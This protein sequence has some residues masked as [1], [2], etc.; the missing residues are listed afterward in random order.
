[1]Q[2]TRILFV[3][4][5]FGAR[6]LI[7]ESYCRLLYADVVEANCSGFET[8]MIG[9]RI[10][11]LMDEVGLSAACREPPTVFERRHNDEFYD[12]VIT[13]CHAASTEQCPVFNAC[14]DSI[15]HKTAE[16]M[17]WS[18]PD[19]K[20]IQGTGDEWMDEARRIRDL[21]KTQ[22]TN[23]VEKIQNEGPLGRRC[24]GLVENPVQA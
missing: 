8:G 1:M 16:V 4:T 11:E 6:S 7:A 21:I 5:Y 17:Q 13:L 15:Y 12:Y 14:V 3:C 19:F 2:K 24:R 9:P 10:F 23:L 18:I 22:V 20:S